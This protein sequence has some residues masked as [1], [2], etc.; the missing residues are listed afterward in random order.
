MP[1][2]YDGHTSLTIDTDEHNKLKEN[3]RERY[4]EHYREQ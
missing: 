4:A 2:S 3:H 1:T